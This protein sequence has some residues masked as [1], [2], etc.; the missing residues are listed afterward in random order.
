MNIIYA[1]VWF[2]APHQAPLTSHDLWSCFLLAV[3]SIRLFPYAFA[4][5]LSSPWWWQCLGNRPNCGPIV[6]EP[7]LG[8]I[9]CA[10]VAKPN[11]LARFVVNSEHCFRCETWSFRHVVGELCTRNCSS[12]LLFCVFEDTFVLELRGCMLQ[13]GITA[14]HSQL[15]FTRELPL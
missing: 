10:I 15:C 12:R 3:G 1:V 5:R 9:A 11:R 4:S 8:I 2:G 7:L 14:F 13:C 6:S